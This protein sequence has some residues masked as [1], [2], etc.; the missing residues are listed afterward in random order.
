MTIKTLFN[1]KRTYAKNRKIEYLVLHYTAG[2]TSRAG[3][4][5]NTACYFK[6][7]TVEA[8][9]DYIVDDENVYLCNSDIRNYYSWSVGGNKY[10]YM[11]TSEGGKYYSKC[12]NRNSIS[13]EICSNKT[14]RNSLSGDDS[15]WYF[16]ESELKLAAELTKEL[17]QKYSI[18]LDRVIMHH[19]VTGKCC[20]NP[21]CL[22]EIRLSK[23]YDFKKRLSGEEPTE[24]KKEDAEMVTES[25]ITVNGKAIKINRILKDN[26]N[27]IELRGLENAGFDVGFD[28]ASKLPILNN[29]PKEL[30]ISVDGQETSVE[31]ININGS[32]YVPIRSIASATGTFDVEYVDGKVVVKT[33]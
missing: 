4:A 30:F 26:K 32:N 5:Y 31:A 6:N 27:Y 19:H 12:T 7:S 25:Y 22:N 10:N 28:A 29:K 11:S 9:A 8:S 1:N 14:N 2:T 23:W 3:S 24:E 13:I 17:M 15:D 33:K 16:T 21:W 18:P 20:P